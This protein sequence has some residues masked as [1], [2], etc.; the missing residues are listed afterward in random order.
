[1]Q[2][3]HCSLH[4]QAA[5]KCDMTR[6]KMQKSEKN[7]YHPPA[8]RLNVNVLLSMSPLVIRA[9]LDTSYVS[10]LTSV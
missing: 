3:K 8:H 4:T 9:V 2:K 6:V 7:R 10:P 1:M 5:L